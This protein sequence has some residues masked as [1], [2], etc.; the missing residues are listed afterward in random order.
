LPLAV[1]GDKIVP[2]TQR[3]GGL[4]LGAYVSSTNPAM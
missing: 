3:F 2:V 4:R 1:T